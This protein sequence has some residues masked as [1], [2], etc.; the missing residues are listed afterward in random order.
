MNILRDTFII[1]LVTFS[2]GYISNVLIFGSDKMLDVR[3]ALFL[4]IYFS[5]I[6]TNF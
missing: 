5:A 6:I 3:P 1:I 4:T 2:F